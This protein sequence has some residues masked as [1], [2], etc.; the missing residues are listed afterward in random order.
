MNPVIPVII[1]G[2]ITEWILALYITIFL[3]RQ[4]LQK[5]LQILILWAL[6]FLSLLVGLS[7]FLG[8]VIGPLLFPSLPELA[9]F[10]LYITAT[11]GL[12]AMIVFAFDFNIFIEY[13]RGHKRRLYLL[14]MNFLGG[15]LVGI[16]LTPSQFT[17]IETELD[18][19]SFISLQAPVLFVGMIFVGYF[20]FFA[21]KIFGRMLTQHL[22][23]PLGKKFVYI[24]G[25]TLLHAGG[26]FIMQIIG[27]TTANYAINLLF[28]IPSSVGLLLLINGLRLNRQYLIYLKQKAFRLIVQITSG[29]VIKTYQFHPLEKVEENYLSGALSGLNQFL[30]TT[31][32]LSSHAMFDAIDIQKYKILCGFRG[33]IGLTLI[34]SDV[35]PIFR[36][37]LEVLLE[38]IPSI[39]NLHSGDQQ[40]PSKLELDQ[41][42]VTALNALIKDTFFFFSDVKTPAEDEKNAQ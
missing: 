7:G 19:I 10:T 3:F 33:D 26:F 4:Y 13:P 21:T 39:I 8:V 34:V 24:V 20:T 27:S 12:I 36:Q 11:I 35:S 25:G 37:T 22:G 1:S 29:E 31:L 41:E 42:K 5:R 38:K 15:L 18:G 16:F 40:K 9:I 2:I 32:N 28:T 30:Q 6:S 17:I 23:T 14:V